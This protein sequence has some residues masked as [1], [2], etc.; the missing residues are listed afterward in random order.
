M[1]SKIQKSNETLEQ[2]SD[3]YSTGSSNDSSSSE[4][5]SSTSTYNDNDNA[6][7]NERLVTYQEDDYSSEE[8]DDAVSIL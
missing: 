3:L 4:S 1:I 8:S 2:R 6:Y 5:E 7:F